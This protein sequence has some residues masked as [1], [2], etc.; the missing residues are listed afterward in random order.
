MSAVVR[1]VSSYVSL[2]LNSL[3]DVCV[4]TED[5]ASVDENL[6]EDVED[7]TV[8]LSWGWKE[9]GN[10]GHDDAAEKKDISR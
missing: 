5:A 10:E 2:L 1:W 4:D 8:N 7:G 3:T 9:E 6:S